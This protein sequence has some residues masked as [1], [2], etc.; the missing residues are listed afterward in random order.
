MRRWWP[1]VFAVMFA[2]G[3]FDPGSLIDVTLPDGAFDWTF[4]LAAVG[5][6][7]LA[8]DPRSE[9]VRYAAT[10]VVLTLCFTR[11]AAI[12]LA[13][14][15]MPAIPAL[16]VL[17]WLVMGWSFASFAAITGVMVRRDAL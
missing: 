12:A 4:G 9:R 3:I 10:A 17:V 7:W 16:A 13:S 8:V 1:L 11:A 14:V 2:A 6:V 15:G 5:S